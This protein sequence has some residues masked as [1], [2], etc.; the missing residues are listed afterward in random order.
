MYF[1]SNKAELQKQEVGLH[2][3]LTK[4]LMKQIKK[5]HAFQG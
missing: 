3:K 1:V 4:K 2:I 5:C